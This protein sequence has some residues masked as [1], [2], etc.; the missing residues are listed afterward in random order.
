M[1]QGRLGSRQLSN[2]Y[3]WVAAVAVVAVTYVGWRSSRDI[4]KASADRTAATELLVLRQARDGLVEYLDQLESKVRA[5]RR[6]L[7]SRINPADV[8]ELLNGEYTEL[9]S[10]QSLAPDLFVRYDVD[11]RREVGTAT[12]SRV[13]P[14]LDESEI[15]ELVAWTKD[16]NN[17]QRVLLDLEDVPFGKSAA[18]RGVLCYT[19]PLWTTDAEGKPTEPDGFLRFWFKSGPIFAKFL[20]PTRILTG[21]YAFVLDTIPET[22]DSDDLP[23]LAWH[24]AEPELVVN[25]GKETDLLN[26]LGATR[27]LSEGGDD[28]AE[29]DLP[30]R[31]GESRRQ[32]LAYVP[33]FFESQHWILCLATP[34]E[35]AIKP[36]AESSQL[37]LLLALIAT[38]I[39]LVGVGLLSYQRAQL[40]TEA[41]ERQREMQHS[42]RELFA[43]NPTAIFVVNDDVRVIDC[44]YGAERLVGL[45]R[46]EAIGAGFLETFAE[47]S[48]DRLWDL[49]VRQGHLHAS[50]A[51]LVRPRDQHP[52]LVELWGRRIGDNWV[53]MAHD[54]EQ[55][56]DLERQ[57]ARL[58]RMDSMGALAWTLAHDF[59]NI[60]GQV[61]ILVSNLRA[62]VG[63]ESHLYADLASIEEKVDDASQ[64][65]TNLME[66]R[67][68]VLSDEPIRPEPLLREFVAH[69]AKVVPENIRFSLDLRCEL[70]DIWINPP[71]LRRVLDNLCINAVDAMAYGGTLTV[72]GYSTRLDA[73]TATDQLPAGE[74]AVIEV[75]DTGAGM[76]SETLDSIFEPFFT[77]KGASRGTGLGLWTVYNI[78]RQVGGWVHV[79]S[80]VGK[81]TRFTAYLPSIRRGAVVK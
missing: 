28:S 35:V 38:A 57:I 32:V 20:A 27:M 45:S 74:Y 21:T 23:R 3:L 64:L 36:A 4:A 19:V 24:M 49:L 37:M 80:R 42:Y 67:Q 54:V 65:I 53:L 72:R 5:L 46:Q 76:S 8:P 56:R 52:I 63:P 15:E 50:D 68:E 1:S 2:L 44:N 51:T 75:L 39:L 59:N 48:V 16:P 22:A 69:H 71:S 29:I 6:S 25:P 14:D 62:E 17:V 61:Q 31:E 70:P 12:L 18:S 60:L 33:V 55:R 47:D 40:L 13:M 78:V 9:F 66:F 79:Q 11:G 58:R 30:D 41:S 7:R 73:S 34:Y 81:G 77:T 43:E 26:A 10:D